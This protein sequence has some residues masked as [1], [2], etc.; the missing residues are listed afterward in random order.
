[1]VVGLEVCL[2]LEESSLQGVAERGAEGIKVAV[3]KNKSA[4]G[5]A[6]S[7]ILGGESYF[8][9]GKGSAIQP[10]TSGSLGRSPANH[11]G[12]QKTRLIHVW[13]KKGALE[14]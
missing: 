3:K 14:L 2:A 12:N 10:H 7:T 1:M 13:D 9:S 5:K 8:R 6:V 11:Q 4:S